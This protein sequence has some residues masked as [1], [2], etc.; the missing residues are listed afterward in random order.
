MQLSQLCCLDH[1]YG[2]K[3]NAIFGPTLDAKITTQLHRMQGPISVEMKG[4]NAHFSMEATLDRTVAILNKDLVIEVKVTPELGK[5]VLQEILPITEGILGAD[6][7]LTLTIAHEGTFIPLQPFSI[8]SMTIPKMTIDLGKVYFSP[9]SQL[10]KALSLL[11]SMKE[12]F[13]VWVTPCYLSLKNGVVNLKR[14][15]AADQRPLPARSL[16][17]CGLSQRKSEYG[18]WN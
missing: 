17:Q 6:K 7:P 18:H 10:A 11:F 16:G 13:Q 8:D 12:K 5:Y 4:K 2:Q 15:D 3:I 9:A 14:S 1:S